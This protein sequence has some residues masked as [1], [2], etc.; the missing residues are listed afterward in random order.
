M[1]LLKEGYKSPNRCG[2]KKVMTKRIDEISC[3]HL[4]KNSEEE[5]EKMVKSIEIKVTIKITIY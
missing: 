5:E 3:N 1:V 4:K 2:E